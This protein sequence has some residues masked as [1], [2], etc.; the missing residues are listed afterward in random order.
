M[1]MGASD[2]SKHGPGP[3]RSLGNRRPRG[4]SWL[5]VGERQG[6]LMALALISAILY[7]GAITARYP[8]SQGL[9]DPR[10]GWYRLSGRSLQAGF[11]FAAVVGLLFLCYVAALRLALRPGGSR[12]GLFATIVGGWLMASAALLRA[13]PGESFDI[14]DYLFRGRMLIE[15]GASPLA[16]P[17]SLFRDRPFYRYITWRGQLDTYGPLWEYASGLV[18]WTVRHVVGRPDSQVVY[19]IG[20]RL[21]A[22]A[23]A[24]LGGV[25]I[26]AIVRARTPEHAPAALLAW[27]WNPLL[28]LATA[29]G[30]HNDMLML[31]AL[32]ASLLLLQRRRWVWGLLALAL[33]AHVKLTALLLLPV[34]GLWMLRRQG[35]RRMLRDGAV[36]LALAIPLSWLLY[37]PLG[38]WTTLRLM[39]QQ[40]ARLL[41]NSPADLVYRLLQER[42]GW[43]EPAAWRITTQG[44]TLLFFAGAAIVLAWF[45]LTDQRLRTKDQ[46]AAH[47]SLVVRPSSWYDDALLWRGCVAITLAYLLIGSF[48]FQHW[49]LLWV[50]APAALLPA[51]RWTQALLPAYALGAL[52][53]NLTDSFLRFLPGQSFDST[54]VGALNVLAQVA[55]LLV[56]AVLMA[57]WSRVGSLRAPMQPHGPASR[58]RATLTATPY[59]TDQ[60]L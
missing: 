54:Q 30:A 23:L 13:Y 28:L 3:A 1:H 59:E 4:V 17:P 24:G 11:I 49:Y 29:V 51:S 48:W 38:G 33:A 25:L 53:S 9:Q 50:L 45:W 5:P 44:A 16:T 35:W 14:F 32:L 34:I 42:Y 20:Y 7:A 27:L 6:A 37:A 40:R 52:W 19:I 58:L 26:V 43:A 41:I 18:A 8:L 39:L 55:P 46:A 57:L 36:A 22:I 21:L 10:A 47:W 12:R 2:D 31:L 60:T 56:I 15:Y